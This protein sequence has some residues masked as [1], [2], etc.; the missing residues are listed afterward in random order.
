MNL[1]RAMTYAA[2]ISLVAS[3]LLWTVLTWVLG[4][5]APGLIEGTSWELGLL[6]V[7]A[8]VIFPFATWLLHED[9]KRGIL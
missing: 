1:L 2:L 9:M 4:A 3:S 8:L 6:V 7:P 5:V